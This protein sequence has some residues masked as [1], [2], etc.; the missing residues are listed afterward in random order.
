[1]LGFGGHYATKSRAYSTTFG[2]LRAARASVMRRANAATSARPEEA[3]D[4]DEDPMLVV[5]IW[6]YAGSGWRTAADAALALAAADQARSRRP[7]RN[8]SAA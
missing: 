1:M 7:V 6:A 4:E 5:G 3:P 8:R 2:Q